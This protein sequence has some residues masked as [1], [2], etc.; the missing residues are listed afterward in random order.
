VVALEGGQHALAFGSGMAA[1]TA[2][3][4]LVH[5]GG[6]GIISNCVINLSPD[7]DAVF[8]EAF[9]VLKPVGRMSVS[10]IVT[11]GQ[12][13]EIIGGS[14]VAWAGCVAGALDEQD[15]LARMRAAGLTDVQVTRQVYANPDGLLDAPEI[16]EALARLDPPLSAS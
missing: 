16:K 9:H 13:P 11:R 10:D 7:K 4:S 8:A 5:A 14:V 1:T 12:L 3:L 15:Y 2:A 6:H